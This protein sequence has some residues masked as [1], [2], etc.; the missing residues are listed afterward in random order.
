[1]KPF[2]QGFFSIFESMAD[3]FDLS[4]KATQQR[5]KARLDKIMERSKEAESWYHRGPW[6]EHPMWGDTWKDRK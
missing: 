2:W 5:M 6:W 3:M 4:G 1:M